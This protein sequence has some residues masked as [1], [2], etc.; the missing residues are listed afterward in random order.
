MFSN[1]MSQAKSENGE[2]IEANNSQGDIEDSIDSDLALLPPPHRSIGTRLQLRR[3]SSKRRLILK[4]LICVSAIFLLLLLVPR[5]QMI[6]EGQPIG[7]S[8]ILL[9][10]VAN[11]KHS[12]QC[13]CLVTSDRGGGIIDAIIFDADRPYSLQGLNNVRRTPN[14][15]S[16]FAAKKPLSL[17]KNSVSTHAQ[18]KFNFTMTYRLDSDLIWSDSYFSMRHKSY[19]RVNKFDEPNEDF[20]INMSVLEASKLSLKLKLKH[21]LAVYMMDNLVNDSTLPPQTPNYLQELRQHMDFSVIHDCHERIGC[22]SYNFMLIVEASYCPDYVHPQFYLALANYVVPVLIGGT[23]ISQLAPPNSYINA[24]QFHTPKDLAAHLIW[25][26]TQPDLYEQ[27]FWW[28]SK[29]QIQ[30]NRQPYC[31]LC[32]RLRENREVNPATEF[33]YWWTQYKCPVPS[34][35]S[36]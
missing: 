20:M 9:W 13:H 35:F 33:V 28:H 14:F 6:R 16:V 36:V 1:R 10:N 34:N 2:Q 7:G 24:D 4:W 15:L 5:H 18:S 17:V 29:Y 8:R 25:L 12:Y 31:H 11:P 27:Y 26:S 21:K 3:L 22:I 32:R 30:L 19:K 23:N